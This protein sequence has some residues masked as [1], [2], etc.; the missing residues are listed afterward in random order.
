MRPR[1]LATAKIL[2]DRE[3]LASTNIFGIPYLTEPSTTTIARLDRNGELPALDVSA[4]DV[5][6]A[7]EYVQ[8]VVGDASKYP[9]GVV[10]SAVVSG[11]TFTAGAPGCVVLSPTGSG[12]SPTVL[13]QLPAAGSFR[14]ANDRPA[15][16]SLT[17]VDGDSRGRP[18]G[19][20]TAP[21]GGIGVGVSRATDVELTLPRTTTTLCGLGAADV[22]NR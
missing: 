4:G 18:R 5:L 20:D 11:A 10:S 15:V 6:T 22:R 9:E 7:R 14:V 13:L 3:P 12:T 21:D 1:V 16:A 2:R 17:F 8:T 19:F